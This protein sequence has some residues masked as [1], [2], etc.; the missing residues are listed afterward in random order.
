MNNQIGYVYPLDHVKS[1]HKDADPSKLNF[2]V[3]QVGHYSTDSS[4]KGVFGEE[5]NMVKFKIAKKIILHRKQEKS[6]DIVTEKSYKVDFL[7]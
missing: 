3:Y 4:Y 5:Y 1:I 2:M 6:S 7:R